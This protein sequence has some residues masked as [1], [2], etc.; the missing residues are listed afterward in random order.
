MPQNLSTDDQNQNNWRVTISEPE[1]D[2]RDG[3]LFTLH[4]V[5]ETRSSNRGSVPYVQLYGYQGQ[6]YV[7]REVFRRAM[8]RYLN[9]CGYIVLQQDQVAV[10][11]K[12]VEGEV[13]QRF[14]GYSTP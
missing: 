3:R 9:A 2:P 10:V 12:M 6:M 1:G 5:G 7:E 14:M 11:V 4:D 13:Q 8:V